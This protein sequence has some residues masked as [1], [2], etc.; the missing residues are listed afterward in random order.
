MQI[1]WNGY[2]FCHGMGHKCI[3]T[4]IPDFDKCTSGSFTGTPEN[5]CQDVH[6]C[7]NNFNISFVKIEPFS[8]EN[9]K[10]IIKYI[11]QNCC[12]GCTRTSEL[13]TFNITEVNSASINTSHLVF[14]ILGRTG[15]RRLYGYYFLPTLD[16]PGGY[17]ITEKR[18]KQE[19]L[20]RLVASCGNLWPLLVIILLLSMIVGFL[21]W[22]M[23]TWVNKEEFPRS[24][25]I[26]LFDGFWWS[27]VSMTT[28]G[29]GDKTPK[30]VISR[31]FAMIWILIGITICSM[32]TASLTTEL[33][34][35]NSPP[36]PDMDGSK[37]GALQHRLFDAYL[38][39]THGG[40]LYQAKDSDVIGGV[41]EL[42]MQLKS[43]N[44][45][46]LFLDMYTYMYVK[47]K[48]TT[49]LMKKNGEQKAEAHLFLKETI[50]TKMILEGE[51]MGYGIL[52]KQEEDYLFFEEFVRNNKDTFETCKKLELNVLQE[53]VENP[54]HNL[55]APSGG[56][57]W[58]MLITSLSGIAVLCCLGIMY[59]HFRK[60]CCK[61]PKERENT[62]SRKLLEGKSERY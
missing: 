6:L 14:P 57:F 5:I 53:V 28:V 30:F 21:I 23:E 56:Y 46:G 33:T 49:V 15:S 62:N 17:Y 25:F 60:Q 24:F 37:V 52:V 44:I 7:K 29:Y 40:T 1:F 31:L 39:A 20:R 42:L 61:T 8:S 59:E 19:V 54:E 35:A 4:L 27:F 34:G 18:S 13:N 16:V 58:P 47:K 11:L 10:E 22:I 26:G 38:I 9:F 41:I 55:F 43:K 45:T 36:I 50:K 2:M 3:R 48:F 12:G 32:F 51:T